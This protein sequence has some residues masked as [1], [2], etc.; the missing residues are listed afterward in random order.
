VVTMKCINLLEL[1][2][3]SPV[4]VYR[5]FGGTYYLRPQGGRIFQ[6]KS[7]KEASSKHSSVLIAQSSVPSFSYIRIIFPN[8]ST[9]LPENERRKFLRNVGN[10]QSA[11][12]IRRELRL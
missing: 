9:L 8:L 2:P 6:T 12:Y 11:S 10:Y 5:R 7:L 3:Y 1:K 4:E